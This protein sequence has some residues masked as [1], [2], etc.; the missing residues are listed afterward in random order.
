MGPFICEKFRLLMLQHPELVRKSVISDRQIELVK[1]VSWHPASLITSRDVSER[2]GCSVAG[3]SA[4]LKAL[5][6]AGYLKRKETTQPS[7]GKEHGYYPAFF[8][9]EGDA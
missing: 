7:G 1:F 8:M 6:G 4:Q 9:P 2:F 3:A 5:V